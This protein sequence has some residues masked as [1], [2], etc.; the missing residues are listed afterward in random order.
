MVEVVVEHQRPL[1]L[2][3]LGMV[4][5]HSMIGIMGYA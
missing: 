4:L 1:R 5:V 3:F 2:Q